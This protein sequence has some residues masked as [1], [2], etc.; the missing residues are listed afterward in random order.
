[1]EEATQLLSAQK[2]DM[3]VEK[4]L[5]FRAFPAV[6][7][8][9]RTLR[10]GQCFLAIQ[11]QQYDGHEFVK[12]AVDKGA[13]VIIHSRSLHHLP[14]TP[15]CLW[16]R[17][18]NTL[19][20]LH[21][22]AH[23]TRRKWGKP[24][25]AVTGSMGKTTTRTFITTLLTQ[26]F[27]TLQ[28]PRNFNNQIGVPLS[29]LRLAA[30]HDVAILELGMNH[31]G[32][33]R[34]LTQISSPTAVVLTNVAAVHRRFFSDLDQ[35]AEAKGEALEHLSETGQVFFN[36]DDSRVTRL[37]ARHSGEKICFGFQKGSDI[38]ILNFRFESPTKMQFEVEVWD[39]LVSA[40]VSMA[41]K[42]HLYNIAA[43]IAVGHHFG[44][45]REQLLSGLTQL[46]IPS[47]RGRIF[48]LE[49]RKGETLTLW[50]D[51]YNSNPA[52]LE[53]VLETVQQLIGYQRKL[54]VL[55]EMLELGKTS[56]QFHRE[57]GRKVAMSEAQLLVTVGPGGLYIQQGAAEQ[58][59]STQQMV[60]FGHSE[61]AAEFLLSEL[62]GGDFLLIKGSRATRMD[63]VVAEIESKYKFVQ[64]VAEAGG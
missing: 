1:M 16:L 20:A 45:S 27:R 54:L 51:S 59:F 60:Q 52:A 10:K 49:T 31:A 12:Q 30:H 23:H 24:L 18:K 62:R 28:S 6:S 37:A 56:S 36:R 58:G 4:D 7:I 57:A 33:I 2:I 13:S 38:R 32:E 46:R 26:V 3:G 34:N 11:G 43:A 39:R 63:R 50:D 15:R 48:Q 47:G 61:E 64:F 53:V 25:V 5:S 55:G 14:A 29:L 22:L 21:I 19:T 35:V 40:V 8:D 17:V 9:S 44:L 42:H 41:G